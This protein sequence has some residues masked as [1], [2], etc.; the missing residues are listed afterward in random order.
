M[1]LT[2]LGN[3][4]KYIIADLDGTIALIDHRRHL[5]TGEKKYFD[6]FN[7]QCVN[8][9]PNT[10]VI[11]LLRL[12]AFYGYTTIICSG[13]DETYRQETIFWLKKNAVAYEKLFMRPKK[14]SDPDN[15][16][17]RMWL[18]TKLPPTEEILFILDDRKKVVDMWREEG[19]TCLQVAPG[20]F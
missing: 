13:R 16:L 12:C 2:P 20:N 5:V 14:N 6:E 4:V 9:I 11:E 18:H 1:K 7:A 10:P 8:D 3:K 19:L 15:E 17:K